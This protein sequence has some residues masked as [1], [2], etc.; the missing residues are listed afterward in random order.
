MNTTVTETNLYDKLQNS[1]TQLSRNHDPAFSTTERT[2]R[3]FAFLAIQMLMGINQIPNNI[4]SRKF[5]F[6]TRQFSKSFLPLL[7]KVVPLLN[8][9][10]RHTGV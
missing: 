10:L 1:H 2:G 3:I 5:S 4:F 9:A 6:F 8:Y 7:Y